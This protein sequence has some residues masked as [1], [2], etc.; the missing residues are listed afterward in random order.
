MPEV[1][2]D[3]DRQVIPR[4]R[5]FTA[6]TE[7]GELGSVKPSTVTFAP[8]ILADVLEEWKDNPSLS[9]AADLTSRAFA[10]G[11]TEPAQDAA[12]FILKHRWATPAARA[13]AR[14]CV[15]PDDT[16]PS[17]EFIARYD[18]P[19]NSEL[20]DAIRS[21]RQRLAINP[22]NPVLWTNLAL[23]Y[24]T[25]GIRYKAEEAM[26]IALALA[27]DNRFVL[28]AGCRMHLHHGDP[29]RAQHL[30][31]KAPSLKHDPWIL[32][33]EIAVAA[34]Q[35]R[36]SKN[37]RR[38]RLLVQ[39]QDFRPFDLSELSAA[40]AT[41][42]ASSGWMKKARQLATFSLRDPS[43]NALAQVG[44]LNRKVV[45][46]NM[47]SSTAVIQS[48]EANAWNARRRGEWNIALTEAKKWQME[49]PFS[50]RPALLAGSVASTVLED[51]KQAERILRF[52]VQSNRDD[53]T[54]FNNLAFALANQGLLSE[55]ADCI[56][57]GW[58]VADSP[59]EAICL[60]A[61]GGLVAFRVG[62]W[63]TGRLMYRQAIDAAGGRNL[64]GTAAIAR[65]YL[66]LEEMRIGS[67]EAEATK[68]EAV[69]ALES[70]PSTDPY[71]DV[72]KKK[73]EQPKAS[74]LL[75]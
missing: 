53:A 24:S 65:T 42:E 18:Q 13:I 34:A 47:P 50:S 72:Y 48:S 59:E 17:D 22:I 68:K 19:E 39:S 58:R 25:L 28:R 70:H 16:G 38:A 7:F 4:W 33:G 1:H 75:V 69:A 23:F 26:R 6:A 40:I 61:T 11:Q 66:A 9:V 35:K 12:R 55:A 21:A 31:T 62:Q 64:D 32:A 37:L 74:P 44:W 41:V 8:A 27:P 60:T 57:Q 54:L 71:R 51:F 29:E 14:R 73:L 49:Q 2:E 20:G 3:R 36:T 30:L 67:S 45:S 52:G 63:E 43:E 5:T 10:I 56:R 15:N 46:F